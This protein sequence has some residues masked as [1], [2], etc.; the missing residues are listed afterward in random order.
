[1]RR[2]APPICIARTVVLLT[3]VDA[4]DTDDSVR[5]CATVPVFVEDKVLATYTRH[6][7]IPPAAAGHNW[8]GGGADGVPVYAREAPSPS[9]D[10][11]APGC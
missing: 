8:G 6:V 2:R 9:L 1:M 5:P 10:G 4:L 7:L 3:F 11:T